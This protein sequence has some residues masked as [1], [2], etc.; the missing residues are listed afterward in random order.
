[1]ERGN[2]LSTHELDRS[3]EERLRVP[4]KGVYKGTGRDI[5]IDEIM[6]AP[7]IAWLP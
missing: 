7:R 5:K 3:K 2:E 6:S 4:Y 1:M